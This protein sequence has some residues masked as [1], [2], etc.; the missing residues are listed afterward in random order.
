MQKTV[1][2][3]SPSQKISAIRFFLSAPQELIDKFTTRL[4]SYPFAGRMLFPGKV[5]SVNIFHRAR[6]S[7]V[8]VIAHPGDDEVDPEHV[9]F[10]L[11]YKFFAARAEADL[12]SMAESRF[13]SRIHFELAAYPPPRCLAES[14]FLQ[15]PGRSPIPLTFPDGPPSCTTCLCQGHAAAHSAM[16]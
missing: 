3:I 11:R 10:L 13:S 8:R 1:V 7:I 14:P 9:A 5:Y 4:D 2:Q 16:S 6:P 15:P 12:H